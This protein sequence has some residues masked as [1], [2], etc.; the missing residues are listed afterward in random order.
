MAMWRDLREWLRVA[1]EIGE[2]A[3]LEGVDPKI[4]LSAI[5]QVNAKNNGPA[6]LF[7]K[8][9]GYEESGFRLLT[10]VVGN[11]K[12]FNLTVGFDIN[13]SLREAIEKLRD[14]PNR[15]EKEAASYPIEYVGTA[16][17]L[18]N[19]EMGERVDLTKFPV[20]ILH[21]KDGGPYIGTGHVVI[22]ADP[23]SGKINAG[24]Y[25]A[26]LFEKNVVGL[27]ISPGKHGALHMNKYFQRNESMPVVMVFG[28]DPLLFMLGGTEVPTGTSELE[29]Y[30]AIR[31][32][33]MKVIRGNITGLPIPANSEIA[34]EGY[35]HPG[36][37]RI[38]GP[39][40]EWTGYYASGARPS[41]IVE[42]KALYYRRDAILNVAV[43]S[44]GSLCDHTFWRSVW[45]SSLIYS[46]LT[47]LGI[48]NIKGVYAPTFG[49]SRQFVIVSI[50]QSY[51]GHATQVGY[52]ASQLRSSAYMGKWVVVVDDDVD[53]Y[54]IDDVMWAVCTRADPAE[55]GVIRKA[56]ASALDPLWS[57][58]TPPSKNTNNRGIIFAVKPY[59]RLEEFPEVS[60][61]SQELRQEV[62]S[63][64]SKAMNSRW[65]S[66]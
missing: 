7:K 6:L 3:Q 58:S 12:L 51:P 41:P 62:F 1:E 22:T 20:P 8:L 49:G 2:L 42:V 13:L 40:G 35:V 55:M 14:M 21:E 30:G 28:P 32:E 23:D 66:Y 4:E 29:Y 9:K 11:I 47:K 27:Y 63:K 24:T 16:D 56:W 34:I 52:L 26:Q 44:K 43:P 10:N 37:T 33:P 15:W 54:D 17:L 5:A 61:A 38:E 39:F 48:P 46:E 50:K 31:G 25:R 45:R 57:K 36:K 19:V 53:P 18:E 60:A 59:E 64:W 65:K